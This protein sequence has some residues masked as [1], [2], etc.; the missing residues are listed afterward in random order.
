MV[1]FILCHA[2]ALH[3]HDFLFKC[4][5]THADFGLP[6]AYPYI[7]SVCHAQKVVS[8]TLSLCACAQDRPGG[9]CIMI[10]TWKT[11]G[12]ALQAATAHALPQQMAACHATEEAMRASTSAEGMPPNSAVQVPSDGA[13]Q[14]GIPNTTSQE[15]SIA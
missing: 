4:V 7:A 10:P 1:R 9:S 14:E 2:A 8:E 13:A 5:H 12:S 15:E 3:H 6:I 11:P